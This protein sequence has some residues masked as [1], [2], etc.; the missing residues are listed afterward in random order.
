MGRWRNAAIGWC[1]FLPALACARKE[2]VAP[3]LTRDAPTLAP[4]VERGLAAAPTQD[5]KEDARDSVDAT[6][7]EPAPPA[8]RRYKVVVSAGDSFNGA[9]SMAL[10]PRFR[11]E[12]ARFV[13]DVWVGVGVGQFDRHRRFADLLAQH[14]PDLVIVSLGA[15][16]ID[17]SDLEAAARSVRSIVQKIGARDCYWIAPAMWKKDTGILEVLERNVAPCRFFSSRGF[18]VER[19]RDGWHPS[20]KGGADWAE[21]FWEWFEGDRGGG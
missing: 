14:K 4:V 1:V 12:G 9:F 5:R 8:P 18:K 21:R 20:V 13:R 2:A 15:N 17:D 10:A 19:G 3:T 7:S 6:D 16:D 11:A